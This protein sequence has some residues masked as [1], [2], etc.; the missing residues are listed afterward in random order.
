ME[1]YDTEEYKNCKIKIFN[2][3][4]TESPREWDNLGIMVCS[5]RNYNLGDVQISGGIDYFHE[6]LNE[7]YAI[8]DNYN[9]YDY[10]EDNQNEI[11]EKWIDKNLIILPL[12]L[13][14]HSGITMNTA[15]F[16]CGWDSGQVGWIYINRAAA[17]KKFGVKRI[18]KKLEK[19]V[20][21]YLVGEVEIY[22]KYLRGDVYGY[23]SEDKDGKDMGSCWGFYDM[24]QL[25]S[26]AKSEIDY[27]IIE[28]QKATKAK[29]Y[30]MSAAVGFC[31]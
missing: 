9:D 18:S 11:I 2:N 23:Q 29:I 30:Q 14:D 28:L 4:D 24:E 21:N 15:G 25:L 20:M 19:R 3:E 13:Y 6:Y 27:N 1:T 8:S 7:K 26:E 5:H 10:F 22:D 12:Y 31:H 16:S 17:R